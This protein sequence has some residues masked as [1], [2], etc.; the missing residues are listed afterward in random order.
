[1]NPVEFKNRAGKDIACRN[2]EFLD[3]GDGCCHHSPPTAMR[4]YFNIETIKQTEDDCGAQDPG[5]SSYEFPRM[6]GDDYCWKFQ[7]RR[8]IR[9][10]KSEVI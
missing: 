2:C 3:D 9:I 10:S 7:M 8:T 6:Y 5:E 4:H 1:M